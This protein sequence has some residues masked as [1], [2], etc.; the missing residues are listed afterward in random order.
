MKI[1]GEN[2]AELY[3][4]S[5]E[6]GIKRLEPH[7]STH[8]NYVYATPYKELAI[9]FSGGCGDDCTYALYKNN[10]NEPWQMVERIP[11]AFNT[12]FS[13]SSSIYTI[14][15][16]TFKDIRTGFA[17]VVSEVGVDTES[18]EYLENVYDAIKKLANNGKIQLYIYPN[19][20]KEIPQDSSDLIDKQIKQQQRNNSS[21]T[22][23]SFERI[24]LLHPNLIDKVNQKMVELNLN[25]EP[26]KKEDLISLFTNAVIR[27]TI[28]PDREQYLK[29]IV[30][31]ISNIYPDLLP[32]LNERL[33]F[34]DKSK[35]EKISYLL[36]E[37]S[38]KFKDIPVELI[39]QAKKQYFTDTRLFSEIGR[40]IIEFSRKAM[41]AEQIINTPINQEILDNSI[42]LIG[43]MG[44]G[45]STISKKLNEVTN[46]P[47]ISLDDRE[48]L[49][50]FYKSRGTFTNFKDFEFYLTSSVLTSMQVPSIIDFGAGHSIYENPIMFY[51][52]QKLIGKFKN[53]ELILP[54]ENRDEALKIVNERLLS[55]NAKNQ[56]DAIDINK[57]FV[58]S[59]CNYELATDIIYTQNM[60]QDEIANAI[61][62]RISSKNI[63]QSGSIKM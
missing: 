14:N 2:M 39:E 30:I 5:S 13:N 26:Y 18:E 41:L 56:Q 17:E 37:L 10:E 46:M 16:M 63:N 32:F 34:L 28:N 11:E 52:M 31:S 44:T 53:V 47:R 58:E 12:M 60:T 23:Q 6:K 15:D 40:E 29:S 55:R 51:E 38:S 35:E 4:G 49:Q 1:R 25:E 22:K 62:E 45:K 19:K 57:H 9:I 33:A 20:P 24:V 27:Q 50:H 43:P 8:G 7:R 3:H 59:P 61:L 36:D 54:C 42:L 21:I 48:Q